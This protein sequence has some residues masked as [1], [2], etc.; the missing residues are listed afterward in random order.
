MVKEALMPS[1]QRPD[2]SA[3]RRRPVIPPRPELPGLFQGWGIK[4]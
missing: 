2:L 1:N 3:E 4:L